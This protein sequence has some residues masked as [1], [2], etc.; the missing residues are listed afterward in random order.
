MTLTG[1]RSDGFN[2]N[3]F[4]LLR[5]LVVFE[6]SRNNLVRDRFDSS[7][8]L[9]GDHMNIQ[10]L[11]SIW[12]AINPTNNMMIRKVQREAFH[13]GADLMREHMNA[14]DRVAAEMFKEQEKGQPFTVIEGGKNDE[15]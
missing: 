8:D 11:W 13:A 7:L 3:C 14:V 6:A 9:A 5:R 12:S 1:V 15:S 4:L 2:S 10:S